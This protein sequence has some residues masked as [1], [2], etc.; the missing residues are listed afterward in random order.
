[1][2]NIPLDDENFTMYASQI[3]DN[4][5]YES[6]EEFSE[7]LNRIKYIK[8]LFFRYDNTGELKLRL[9]LNHIIILTNV[10]GNEGTTRILFYKSE[11]KYYGY[12]KSF[13]KYLNCLPSVIPELD[14]KEINTDHRI[15][16]H[17]DE[18]K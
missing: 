18:L 4:P 15:D 9:I 2:F 3:Y 6:D 13:L 16:K 10:F 12:I 5:S 7:D 14:L 8:R 17:L 11:E 1:M